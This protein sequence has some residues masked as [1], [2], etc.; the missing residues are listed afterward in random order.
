MGWS[1][2]WGWVRVGVRVG[3]RASERRWVGGQ[4]RTSHTRASGR[5]GTTRRRRASRT[6]G[7]MDAGKWAETAA[8]CGALDAPRPP[9]SALHVQGGIRLIHGKSVRVLVVI[10]RLMISAHQ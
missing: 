2:G 1:W 9:H 7:V 4:Q 3:A 6:W 5:V 10:S 8:E